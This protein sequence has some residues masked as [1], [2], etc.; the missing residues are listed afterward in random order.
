MDGQSQR[1]ILPSG[2]V[3]FSN[4]LHK[5]CC[6]FPFVKSTQK[7]GPCFTGP[8]A[9]DG[10]GPWISTP[11]PTL[12]T[13]GASQL[14]LWRRNCGKAGHGVCLPLVP[15]WSNSLQFSVISLT[16]VPSWAFV[17]V[18]SHSPSSS[19]FLFYA[20]LLS[21]SAPFLWSSSRGNTSSLYFLSTFFTRVFLFFFS[22][23]WGRTSGSDGTSQELQ[24]RS[25]VPFPWTV[26][27]WQ[28]CFGWV[29][30]HGFPT[31]GSDPH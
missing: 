27:L 22:F 29:W 24:M 7:H 31:L 3:W 14:W 8:T 15:S 28:Y 23:M 1:L 26:P 16:L 25:V 30:A 11:Q 6:A 19:N 2:W 18:L 4:V 12:L 10:L 9:E 21:V 5:E 20:S 17:L 13:S